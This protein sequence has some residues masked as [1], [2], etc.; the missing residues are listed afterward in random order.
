MSCGLNSCFILFSE[1]ET[2]NFDSSSPPPPPPP[3]PSSIVL[4]YL[5][6]PIFSTLMRTLYGTVCT[7]LSHY[8]KYGLRCDHNY[9]EDLSFILSDAFI[10]FSF[11]THLH[12]TPQIHEHNVA[13]LCLSTSTCSQKPPALCA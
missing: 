1:T 10:Q 3:P 8:C 4:H 2:F 5:N 13:C 6:Q 7:Q 12:D 9:C 11:T